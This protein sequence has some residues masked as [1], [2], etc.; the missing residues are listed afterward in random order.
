MKY[1]A[2]AFSLPSSD[3]IHT[4]A[5]FCWTPEN[6]VG[7]IQ[8]SHGM[9]EY[10]LRYTDFAERMCDAGFAVVGHDHLGHGY[11]A[12]NADELGYMTDA[13]DPALFLVK[14][15]Y[16]VNSWIKSTFPS[17]PVILY[18]HSM[19]SFIARWALTEYKDAWN[20]A[21]ISGTAGPEAPTGAGLLLCRV[22]GIFGKHNRSALLYNIA[23]GSYDKPFKADGIK[24]AWLTR[25]HKVI[26][27]YNADP[28]CS[29]RFTINGYLTL[30]TL[31]GKV[32]AKDWASKMPLDLPML[33]VSG[34]DDPVGNFGKGVREVEARLRKAG[35]KELSSM[36]F[37]GMRHEPHNETDNDKFFEGVSNIMH[38]MIQR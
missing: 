28:F 9:C 2:N 36:Y 31:L 14:D 24:N 20:A 10:I 32:S 33:L 34:E 38:R 11:T 4:L 6:P 5:A 1:T 37:E 17:L 26:E 7:V 15:V 3:G 29:Y 35:A 19:G 27:K 25:D 16:A 21:V 8:L 22:L 13:K 18:G 23:F 30:F 12:R